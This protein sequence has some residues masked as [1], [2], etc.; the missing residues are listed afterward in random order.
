MSGLASFSRFRGLSEPRNSTCAVLSTLPCSPG[1]KIH[2]DVDSRHECEPT[3]NTG[4]I[5]STSATC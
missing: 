3:H 4:G 1:P 5:P 2:K